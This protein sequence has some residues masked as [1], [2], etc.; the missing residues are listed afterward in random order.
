M[1]MILGVDPG[2]TGALALADV[3][4]GDLH[5]VIDMP[6]IENR[7]DGVAIRMWLNKFD[8]DY[9]VIEKVHSM[10][11]QGVAS[12]FKFG[13]AYGLVLGVVEGLGIP[14][15]L[16]SPSKWKKDLEVGSDK[17][18]ARA[19]ALEEWPTS[20]FIFK[21][22]KDHGRAEAALLTKWLRCQ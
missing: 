11:Q 10:P 1:K 14:V 16:V 9:A 6:T 5:S 4:T 13:A 15:T 7:V 17:E 18:I 19:A 8:I 22:K 2:M 12:T 3:E 21:R 20:N